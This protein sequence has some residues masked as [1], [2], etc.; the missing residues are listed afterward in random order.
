MPGTP[1]AAFPT[2]FLTIPYSF[3]YDELQEDPGEVA[4]EERG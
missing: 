4:P 3:N 2:Y 1:Q